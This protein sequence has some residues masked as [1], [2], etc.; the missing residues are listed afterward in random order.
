MK[1]AAAVSKKKKL[2]S[3]KKKKNQFQ[4]I[5]GKMQRE[6][7]MNRRKREGE[8]LAKGRK[9]KGRIQRKHKAKR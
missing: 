7:K 2:I 8:N 3:K 9:K 4:K 6:K 1:S 5:F